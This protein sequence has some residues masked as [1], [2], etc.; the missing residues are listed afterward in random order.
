M[1][2]FRSHG[3]DVCPAISLWDLESHTSAENWCA[4][5]HLASLVRRRGPWYPVGL[6]RSLHARVSRVLACKTSPRAK[7]KSDRY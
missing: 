3:R 4:T 5:S 1:T 6:W 2:L 7:L